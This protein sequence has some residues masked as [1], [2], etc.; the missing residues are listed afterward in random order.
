GRISDKANHSG[1]LEVNDGDFTIKNLRSGIIEGGLEAIEIGGLGTHKISNAGT[2]ANYDI[3]QDAIVAGNGIEKVTNWG[4]I[5]GNHFNGG[6]EL[7]DGADTFTNFKKIGGVIKH[8]TVTGVIDLGAGDDFF[9]GG[10]NA[11][12]VRDGAGTDIYKL[13]AGN[14][15]YLYCY[16]KFAP[17]GDGAD[18]VNAGSGIDTYDA[19]Q[20]GT[21]AFVKVNL[22]EI[23]HFGIA[24]HSGTLAGGGSNLGTDTILGFENASGGFGN[25]VLI[26]SNGANK[27]EGG[28]GGDVLFGLGGADVL[29]GDSDDYTNSGGDSFVFIAL[30]DSGPTAATR[31]TSADFEDG[32]DLLDLQSLNESLGNHFHFIGND[33]SFDGSL[34]AIIAV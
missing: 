20:F 18:T 31:D 11:E 32:S 16:K 3:A 7:G 29:T 27:L 4:V 13:G 26:G 9:N 6:V 24:P 19:S 5:K 22:D 34:G 15:T 14:D 10:K 30:K 1:I 17:S 33:V 8:G 25:D 12:K 28:A 23:A 2:I 21:D